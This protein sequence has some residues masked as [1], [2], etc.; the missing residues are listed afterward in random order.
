MK[1]LNSLMFICLLAVDLYPKTKAPLNQ[2]FEV[3]RSKIFSQAN[4]QAQLPQ[5]AHESPSEVAHRFLDREST[6]LPDQWNGLSSF[7]VDTPKP[8]WNEVHVVDIVDVGIDTEGDTTDVSISTNWL[9]DLDLSIRLSNYPSRRL[10]FVFP[11]ASACFGDHYFGFDL[12]LS[13]EYSATEKNGLVKQSKGP[14]A[15]RIKDR[16][17]EPLLTLEA[18]IRYVTEMRDKTADPVTKKNASKTLTI[19]HSF[20]QGKPLPKGLTIGAGNGCG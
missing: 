19:L 18:A 1:L 10:P 20:Q 9:G 15:W 7:F 8:K 17:F 16:S 4:M 2:Y 3:S 13:D 12:V 11:S 6:S 5:P 14:L